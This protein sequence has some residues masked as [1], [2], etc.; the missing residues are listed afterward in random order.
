MRNKAKRRSRLP[1]QPVGSL[2]KVLSQNE[3]VGELLDECS[4]ELS[5][6]STFFEQRLESSENAWEVGSALEQNTAIKGK[7][8]QASEKL[9]IVNHALEDQVRE[10]N[11]LDHQFA[12][13][14]EQKEAASHASLHDA[15]TGL[16]NRA[17]FNDRLEHGLAHAI[18]HDWPLAVMF[19]DLN[20]F[21]AINDALGHAVGDRVLQLV[22]QRLKEITRTDDTIS[23]YGGDEFLYLLMEIGDREQLARIAQ[24]IVSTIELPFEI[25][26]TLCLHVRISLGIAI[27][28]EDGTTA[29]ALIKNADDAMYSAK[30][31]GLSFAFTG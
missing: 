2:A 3:A 21:K 18:R 28:P 4:Q 5:S 25:E 31:S 10:R 23:R 20:Q 24:N 11:M 29:R 12:A 14:K 26:Q 15:L 7:V 13:A 16:P 8:Q 17:L 9:A 27:Y 30:Q 22:A 6:V 1:S 19:L